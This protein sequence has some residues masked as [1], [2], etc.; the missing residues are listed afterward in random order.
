MLYLSLS[1]SLYIYTHMCIYIYIH[2]VYLK[3]S[4]CL[5]IALV[6]SRDPRHPSCEHVLIVCRVVLDKCIY[7]LSLYLSLCIYI[8]IYTNTSMNN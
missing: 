6:C 4:G 7:V 3:E 1:L 5:Y 8:Y 2:F